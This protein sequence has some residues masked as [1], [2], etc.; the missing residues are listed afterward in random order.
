MSTVWQDNAAAFA[1]TP[2]SAID[3]ERHA[4]VR[5]ALDL[6]LDGKPGR[7]RYVLARSVMRQNRIAGGGTVTLHPRCPCGG[8]CPNG[9][10]GAA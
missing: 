2:Q 8:R 4:A 9:G 1:T 5:E 7:A 6:I 3:Q 10:G